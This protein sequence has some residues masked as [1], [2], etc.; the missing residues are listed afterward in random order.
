MEMRL[1]TCGWSFPDWKGVFYPAGTKDELAFYAT[2]LDAVEIDSTW[3]RIPSARTVASWHRRTPEGFLFCPK[4]PGEI[5]HERML[6]GAADLTAAFLDVIAGL[7][8]KLGPILVQL[9]PSFHADQFSKLEDFLSELPQ[10]FRYVVEFR[11]RSWV[12]MPEALALLRSLSMGLAMA[13]HPWYPRFQE[14]TTD[15]AYLRLL[16]RRGVFPD[17]SRVHQ[18]RDDALGEWAGVLLSMRSLI[19][20]AYVFANNQFEGYS[21]STIERLRAMV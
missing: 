9:H 14:A 16:G 11:H 12:K 15:F 17:F 4:L 20:R 18:P 3:Y 21:P 19:G 2:R 1:G 5:T 10:E 6:E 13:H 7:Q 8:E